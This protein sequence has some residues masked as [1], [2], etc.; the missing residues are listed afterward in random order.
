MVCCVVM[1]KII[2]SYLH[3]EMVKIS[4]KDILGLNLSPPLKL[5]PLLVAFFFNI[6][7]DDYF[8]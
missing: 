5:D 7:S 1:F 2:Y 4:T 6:N 3:T 8:I